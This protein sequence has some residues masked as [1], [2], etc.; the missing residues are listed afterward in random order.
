MIPGCIGVVASLFILSVCEQYYQF[1]LG[2]GVLGGI[3]ASL[4]FTPA[5]TVVGHWFYKRRGIATGIACTGG[6]IGGIVFPIAL[7]K[8]FDEVGYGWAI[9]VIAFIVVALCVFACFATR[10]R[11]P[12]NTKKGATIDVLALRDPRY[13]WTT[14]G[15]FLIE[16]A[17]FIPLQYL[18]SYS[19]AHNAGSSL[20]YQILSIV[21]AGSILGRSLPG[22]M[23]DRFGRFNVM[24]VTTLVCG[25]FIA[26]LWLPAGDSKAAIILFALMFG[27]WSGTGICLT[28]VCVSQICKTEDY[29]K[30]YGTTFFL[31]SFAALTG[32]PIAGAIQSSQNGSFSGLIIF[33]ACI[34]FAS[35]A[36]FVIARVLGAGWSIKTIY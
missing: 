28:P 22:Y 21:N 4:V 23:A 20:P 17:I 12:P 34:Y 25:I 32:L 8:L 27:F 24:I 33:S 14:V 5:V 30:R 26:A 10:T 6:A 19:L 11:L 13:F 2:F 31:A 18:P 15:V 3:S 1:L 7:D 36:A 35:S 9:R 16:W 29:G